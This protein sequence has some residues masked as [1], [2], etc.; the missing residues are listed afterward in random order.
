M[1]RQDQIMMQVEDITQAI[2]D[3]LEAVQSREEGIRADEEELLSRLR[4]KKANLL[5]LWWAS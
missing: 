4:A 2:D 1:P 5:R 3:I